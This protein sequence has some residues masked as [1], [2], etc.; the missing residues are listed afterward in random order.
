LTYTERRIIGLTAGWFAVAC[1]AVVLA[2]AI[3]IGVWR[4]GWFVAS[5][6]L[7]QQQ[8]LQNQQTQLQQR[9]L[10]SQAADETD[11]TNQI[12]AVDSVTAQMAAYPAQAPSSCAASASQWCALR[13]QRLGMAAIA[14]ADAGK[15]ISVP[16]DQAAWVRLNCSAGV[17]SLASPLQK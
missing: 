10:G 4:L 16:A 6:N 14:C 13:A 7:T 8:K 3:G 9:S 15:L 5:A 17:V 2:A 12:A 1:I 11:M